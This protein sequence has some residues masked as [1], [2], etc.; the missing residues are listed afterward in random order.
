MLG[1][2]SGGLDQLVEPHLATVG[3]VR[4]NDQFF[5][6]VAAMYNSLRSSAS[7]RD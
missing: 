6:G 2:E 5:L 3:L 7:A 1:G 4:A